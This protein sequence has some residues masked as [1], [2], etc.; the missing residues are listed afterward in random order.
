VTTR[1]CSSRLRFSLESRSLY[2]CNVLTAQ[3]QKQ[4]ILHATPVAYTHRTYPRQSDQPVSLWPHLLRAGVE[5][6][7]IF[8]QSIF[9]VLPL[10]L[11]N[12]LSFCMVMHTWFQHDEQETGSGMAL[13]C[14]GVALA[15]HTIWCAALAG[16]FLNTPPW[17]TTKF[18]N[19]CRI[20]TTERE[21]NLPDQQVKHIQVLYSCMLSEL[22]LR[23]HT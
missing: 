10:G 4:P 3:A 22:S 23:L 14:G 5:Q 6:A 11:A 9:L 8:P 21:P 7:V 18:T 15:V 2:V 16:A 19:Y 20:C 13:V 17:T 1:K 12:L